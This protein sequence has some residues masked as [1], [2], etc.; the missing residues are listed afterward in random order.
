[1]NK[2]IVAG[3]DE[4]GRGAW[5]GPIVA[6]AVVFLKPNK[7]KV[8]DSKQLNFAQREELSKEIKRCAVWSIG[9][10]SNFDIDRLGLQPA[11]ILAAQRA[12]NNLPL[13]PDVL[14]VDMIRKFTH[15]ID[16]ELIIRGDSKVREISAASIIAKN[17]RDKM[18]IEFAKHYKDYGFELHKG[19]GTELHQKR[20]KKYG[21]SVLHR[22]SFVPIAKLIK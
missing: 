12:A 16:F 11:N 20:L 2:V 9:I 13:K 1:M 7:L 4:V 15:P 17:H 14:K 22:T 3:I 10:V 21:I 19:Y 18:M 8:V 5:A 6:A